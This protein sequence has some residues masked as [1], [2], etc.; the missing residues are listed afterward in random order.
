MITIGIDPGISGAVAILRTQG[1]GQLVTFHDTPTRKAARGQD[2]LPAEM[3][4][5]LAPYGNEARAALEMAR[6]PVVARGAGSG[7]ISAS[8]KIGRGFGLWEGLLAAHGIA[9]ELPAASAWK[10]DLAL[11]GAGA[12]DERARKLA[13]RALAQQLFPTYA[14]ELGK[15][16]PDFAEALLL[17][18]WAR[19]RWEGQ[20]R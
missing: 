13:A 6:A 18:E 10:K 4:A 5:I 17:A 1:S 15:R 11:A 12:L 16:R 8:F 9:Y 3:A 14:V 19:R 2:Y 7:N 20:R